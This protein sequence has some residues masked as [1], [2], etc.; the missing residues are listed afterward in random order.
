MNK[1]LIISVI[2]LTLMGGTAQAQHHS[3]DKALWSQADSYFDPAEMAEARA[4]V[5]HHSGGEV[6]DFIMADR[7]E[8]QAG[9]EDILVWD[10]QAWRGGDLQKLWIKSEGEYSFDHDELEEIEIQAL[11]SR[12]IL[13]YF[14]IQAGLR[15]D[16]EPK[17]KAYGVFG[18]Q[19]L[20][21]YGFEVDLAGFI[22]TDG[23]VSARFEGEY[24]WLLTQRLI[25]QPRVELAWSGQ[26]NLYTGEGAGVSHAALG[27]RL[28]YEFKREFAP[29]IGV[30]WQSDLGDTRD[31]TRLN[32]ED[33]EQT[34]FLI[35]LRAWY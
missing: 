12:A 29:Y 19:G 9:D 25:A 16:L 6:T 3:P 35:G 13:P 15:Y 23:D 32:G 26:S 33:P 18:L 28:R 10:V 7:L 22:S 30:E 4:A 27:L 31:L 5:L 21:P 2:F 34:R 20:V 8:W 17:G 14:D 1:A 11:Y 24:D